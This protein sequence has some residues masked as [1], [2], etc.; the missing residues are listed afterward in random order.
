MFSLRGRAR[1]VWLGCVFDGWRC[2][3]SRVDLVWCRALLLHARFEEASASL[4]LEQ[5]RKVVPLWLRA[6]WA[7]ELRRV[8]DVAQSAAERGQLRVVY[9]SARSL[10][11]RKPVPLRSV[12]FP[13]GTAASCEREVA[14]AWLR[15]F[16]EQL[17]ARFWRTPI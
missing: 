17:G 16:A 3:Q 6:D 5:H 8:S 13:D 12:T 14:S 2:C 1:L 7:A 4:L 15:V 11:R 10:R 9:E